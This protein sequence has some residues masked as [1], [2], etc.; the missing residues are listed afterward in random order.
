MQLWF[1]FL[2]HKSQFWCKKCTKGSI[3]S[4]NHQICSEGDIPSWQKGTKRVIF[5]I[6]L[7]PRMRAVA[8]A[9]VSKHKEQN[10]SW[11]S[12]PINKRSSTNLYMHALVI[13]TQLQGSSIILFNKLTKSVQWSENIIG[14]YRE[15]ES[16]KTKEK[17][18]V[19][20][21]SCFLFHY[22]NINL[23]NLYIWKDRNL[24][25][26]SIRLF[27]KK[28]SSSYNW[29]REVVQLNSLS[30]QTKTWNSRCIKDTQNI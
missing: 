27:C 2:F 24:Q 9:F 3:L 19:I 15:R 28:H 20:I 16:E 26:I 10:I 23:I 1:G 25:I 21:G 7:L 11:N 4:L 6:K 13:T 17:S 8:V 12:F 18:S 22:K 30:L 29:K 14:K 5:C